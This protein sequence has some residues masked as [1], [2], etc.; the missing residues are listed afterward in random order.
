MSKTTSELRAEINALQS[1]A[2]EEVL[3]AGKLTARARMDVIFDAG[4]FVEVGAFIGGDKDEEFCPVITGYGAVNGLLVFAFSQDYSRLHGAMGK[5][6]A[7][8]ICKIIEMAENAHAPLI[9]VFDSAGAMIEE[10]SDALAG[11]GNIMSSVASAKGCI[12]MTAVISGPCGGAGAV[13]A[14]MFDTIIVAEKT[15]SLYMVPS[16]ALQDKTLGK[17]EKLAETG[18]SALTAEDD[19]A[20]CRAA[21]DL[22]KYFTGS[23]ETGDDAN[24]AFD[25]S[26]ISGEEYDIHPVIENLVDVG[27]FIE[28]YA[29][30][31]PQM[32]L[33]LAAVNSHVCGIIANN[34]SFKGGKICPG[35]AEKAVK[36][37]NLCNTLCIP[38]ITLVDG[39][40][41]GTTDKIEIGGA[42]EKFAKL[43]LA[44]TELCYG[45]ITAVL[46]KAYGSAFTLLGSKSLGADMTFALDRAKIAAMNPTTA[47]E[48]LGEVTDESK[49]ALTAE[50]WAEKAASPLD[51]AKKGHI[52]DIIEASELRARISAALEMLS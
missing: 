39:V 35:A 46:G 45:K 51:A 16:V 40:G 11:C 5:Q 22:C 15:G 12:P 27:T 14:S 19:A 9:G 50:E 42:A 30:R 17:P 10:G 29:K 36:L 41:V 32:T 3:K 47:V 8:K 1:F 33:G 7:E 28:L 4:T 52:D 25:S 21:A 38:V 6:H 31:A 24:R 34:P 20:A 48:F 18:V 49:A 37:I 23:I 26:L 43:A 13:I 44:Y 2:S